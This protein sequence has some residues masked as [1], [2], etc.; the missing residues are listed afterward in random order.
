MK[1]GQYNEAL[2]FY[3]GSYLDNVENNNYRQ[4]L[5][6]VQIMEVLI[7]LMKFEICFCLIQFVLQEYKVDFTQMVV[8]DLFLCEILA[9]E[10]K[11]TKL[12]AFYQQTIRKHRKIIGEIFHGSRFLFSIKIRE[13]Q[14]KVL[15]LKIKG[16]KFK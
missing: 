13:F 15:M 11:V 1:Y 5:C 6:L 10:R 7:M 2:T 14:C 9:A 3:L 12:S 16:P 8:I 4:M